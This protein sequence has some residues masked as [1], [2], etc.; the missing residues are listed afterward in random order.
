MPFILNAQKQADISG[1]LYK[2][3]SS[4]R[5]AQA[6]ITNL[7]TKTVMM[8][9]ELGIFTIKASPGDTLLFDKKGYEP[10]KKLVVNLN[11]L[12]VY[13]KPENFVQLDEVK[14]KGL[15][16]RQELTDI[17]KSYRSQG[18]FFD[19]KPPALL[20]LTSPLTG[21][22]ELFGKTPGNARRFAAYT[23]TELEQNEVSRRYNREFVKR[24]TGLHDDE[25]QQFMDF[26]K[27]SYEDLKGWNDYELLK[28]IK[29]QFEYYKNNK[30]RKTK[31]I[32]KD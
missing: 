8:S 30:D 31:S 6:L 12:L 20:F 10:Y 16:K 1:A 3:N 26:Y 13:L 25:V 22:Y 18:V 4:T 21:L 5:L 32:F 23:K 28:R 2:E 15:T 7:R 19:G 11:D 14:I 17:M 9:D 29:R 27:P 24:A